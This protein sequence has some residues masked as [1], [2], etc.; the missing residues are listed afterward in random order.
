MITNSY[1]PSGPWCWIQN[2]CGKHESKLSK[3]DIWI[4]IMYTFMWLHILIICSHFYK[5]IKYFTKRLRE[6]RNQ[7]REDEKKFIKKNKMILYCFPI[8]LILSK[9]PAT[10]N[11]VMFIFFSFESL[12]LFHLQAAFSPLIGILNSFVFI[13][14]HA[15]FLKEKKVRK[16]ESIKDAIGR[17]SDL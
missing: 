4:Y 6:I 12:I 3:E 11:R 13:H 9:T 7:N 16:I 17:S 5:I 15:A 2:P 1:G 8:I 14:I 10:I